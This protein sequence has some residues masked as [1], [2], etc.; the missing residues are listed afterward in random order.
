MPRFNKWLSGIPSGATVDHVA[1]RALAVRLRAVAHYLDA[2]VSGHDEA[3]GVH[4]LRIW[5]R[6]AG[7]ALRLFRPALPQ[8]RRRAMK[9]LL[10][11]LR[12]RAGDI[13]D[14]DVHLDRLQADDNSAPGHVIKILKKER[15]TA[16][17]KLRKL[18]S[19][20]RKDDSFA[21]QVEQ[22]LQQIAWPK[23]HSTRQ[24]PEFASW[25]R[26]EL[27]PLA[28]GYFELAEGNLNNDE[29]LHALRIAG[30]RWRYALELSV[31]A[32]KPERCRQLDEE[33]TAAQDRLGEICD[34]MAAA[35]QLR[36]WIAAAK[37]PKRAKKLRAIL[38]G[39]QPRQSAARAA[40]VRWWTP[41]RRA[42]LQRLWKSAS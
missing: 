11:K 18:R 42:R 6:R 8:A 20:L 25:C 35:D 28:T 34:Q 3:E 14:A 37:K 7:A 22:L 40:F 31:T 24:A 9:K 41:A 10:R 23:R 30:K 33:L 5:T 2:A 39:V 19:R 26:G 13:R 36:D 12:R 16:R 15:R 29:E 17:R 32:L 1:R 4:Q 38:K 27:T 21:V